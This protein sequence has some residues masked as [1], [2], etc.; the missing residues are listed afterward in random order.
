[1]GIKKSIV[2]VSFSLIFVIGFASSQNVYSEEPIT[3]STDK[4]SYSYGETL[5]VS[6]FVATV[7]ENQIIALVITKPIDISPI[8]KLISSTGIPTIIEVFPTDGSFEREYVLTGQDWDK[9]GTY[10]VSIKYGTSFAETTFF[11]TGPL[12]T[13]QSVS[14][15]TDK[16]FYSYG[17][18]LVVSGSVPVIEEKTRLMLSISDPADEIIDFT[19]FHLTEK[20]FEQKYVLTGPHWDKSGVYTVLAIYGTTRGTEAETILFFTGASTPPPEP[21]PTPTMEKVPGWIKNNAK[22]WAEGQIGDSDF[23]SGIQF[24]IK[25]KIVNIPN[26]PEQASET[27]EEKVPDWI[28]N[29]AGWWADGLISEDDFVNGIKYLVEHGI[30]RV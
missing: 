9:S 1:M 16:L 3:V 5:V 23:V 20:S 27:A 21:E 22:W 2:L 24:M 12:R 17:E 26:L 19:V 13:S 10:T 29:N 30:I 18:T 4:S 7:E 25:E 14:V 8:G 11:F 28:R 15:S 6:G